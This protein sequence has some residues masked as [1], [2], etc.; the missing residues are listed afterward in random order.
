MLGV[1]H[2]LSQ[3]LGGL[4]FAMLIPAVVALVAEDAEAAESF[5]LVAGLTGFVAGAIFFAL[6]GRRWRL[7]RVAAIALMLSAWVL[8]P[9]IAAIPIAAG[10]RVDYLSALFEAVSGYTTT[11]ATVLPSVDTLGPAIVFWRAE[12]QWLGGLIT[13]LSIVTI[14]A[15]AG[16]GGLTNQNVALLGPASEGGLSRS[17]AT[18]RTVTIMYATTTALC[19]GMLVIGGIP[20]FDAICIAFATIST[21]GFM[22]GDGSLAVYGS[23]FVELVVML[24]MLVGATSIVWHRML[25][26]GRW[27]LVMAHRES[28][29]VIGVALLAGTAFAAAFAAPESGLPDWS[30][31]TTL[32]H[33][34]FVGVS[35]VSTTGFEPW[36]GALAALPVAAVAALGIIGGGT[37]STAGGIKFY[38]IG[39]MFVQSMDELRR[40]VYPHSVRSTHFGSQ[41][42][43]I[44]LIKAI[45]TSSVVALVLVAAATLLLTLNHPAFHGGALAAIS[46]FSNI[47]P[48]Y[49]AAWDASLGWPDYAGFDPFSKLVMIVTMIVGRMEAVALLILAS[50]A[51]WRS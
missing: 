17:F 4:A 5:L 13:L 22:P 2:L 3:I 19:F 9:L 38:R 28:Y 40:L 42:Y 31:A 1:L 32:R 10:A 29:W 36:P 30:A 34:V 6:K 51:Y 39:G 49:S 44:Q 14:L 15:P 7:S 43:D 33:G 45:W 46:A 20:A 18:A 35:I 37:M 48:L 27:P 47:G 41:P 21:G 8:P 16:V 23:A 26:Q 11:G 25:V 24:F 12:L 50:L